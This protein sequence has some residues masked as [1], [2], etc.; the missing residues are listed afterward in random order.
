[1]VRVQRLVDSSPS[2]ASKNP[3]AV[4]HLSS[5]WAPGGT[6]SYTGLG[7]PSGG[8]GDGWGG[9][10][11]S[12]PSGDRLTVVSTNSPPST[13]MVTTAVLSSSHTRA[14]VLACSPA[15]CDTDD[16]AAAAA[17][18]A[19]AP[20]GPDGGGA[21]L[22]VLGSEHLAI[23]ARINTTTTMTPQMAKAFTGRP[24]SF[25]TPQPTTGRPPRPAP[26]KTRRQAPQTRPTRALP[27]PPGCAATWATPRRWPTDRARSGCRDG[28]R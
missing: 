8:P 10:A 25:M 18:T 6:W 7:R 20:V 23:S 17:P 4:S 12:H 26:A 11:T 24:S 15:H 21:S 1:M 9:M 16:S 22:S 28:R 19:S 14:A 27:S 3:T 5:V 13:L 2:H